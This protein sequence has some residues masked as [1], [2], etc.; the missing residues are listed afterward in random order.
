[1]EPV[2]WCVESYS[3]SWDFPT[4]RFGSCKLRH[5]N[6]RCSLIRRCSAD[7]LCGCN[8]VS[9]D[10]G[11]CSPQPQWLERG[12]HGGRIKNKRNSSPIFIQVFSLTQVRSKKW[13]MGCHRYGVSVDVELPSILRGDSRCGGRTRAFSMPNWFSWNGF[14]DHWN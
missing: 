4:V 3:R 7:A 8:N 1:M 11:F 14:Q 6:S 2:S 10:F 12:S 9:D 5:T 13:T